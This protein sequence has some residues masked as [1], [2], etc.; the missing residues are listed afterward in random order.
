[1]IAHFPFFKIYFLSAKIVIIFKITLILVLNIQHHFIMKQSILILTVALFF[2]ACGSSEKANPTN[3]EGKK[4]VLVEKE[5]ALSKLQKEV[6]I[7]KAEIEKM[8]P[9]KKKK[10][11]LVSTIPV[12]KKDFQHFVD[13]QGTVQSD[14]YVNVT[15]EVPGRILQMNWKEG[16]YVR[17]GQ[18]VAS[19]DMEQVD[20]QIAEL[21]KSLELAQDVYERQK[22]LWDQDIGSEMQFLQAKNSKERLEKSLETVKFQMTKAKVYAPISG[23]VEMVNLKSGEVAAPGVPIVQILNTNKVKVV[24]AVPENYLQAVKK[25]EEVVIRFPALNMEKKARISRI[26]TTI[27]PTNRTFEVEVDLVNKKELF[28]PNLL[29]QMMI[30]DISIKDAVTIPLV[31]LQQDVSGK[32]FVYITEKTKEG[33]AAKKVFVETGDSYNDDIVITKG[34]TGTEV[35]IGEGSRGIANRELIRGE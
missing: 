24:A 27:N 7:L 12:A 15:S 32:S 35:L 25:G 5:S 21:N 11:R 8:E 14:D 28:K 6:A 4:T 30:N 17:K 20:K 31:L 3:L 23:V 29:A 2:I 9:P 33:N 16:Q 1:M 34:L 22:R 18:L 13:I 10:R 19:L 26:G